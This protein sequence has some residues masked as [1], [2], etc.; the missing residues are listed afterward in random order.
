MI[1]LFSAACICLL[2]V[3]AFSETT[4]GTTESLRGVLIP[5]SSVEY[6]NIAYR[7]TLRE[8]GHGEYLSPYRPQNRYV[9]PD[10]SPVKTLRKVSFQLDEEERAYFFA[11]FDALD[12]AACF[13]TNPADFS[14]SRETEKTPGLMYDS[15]TMDG[16]RRQDGLIVLNRGKVYRFQGNSRNNPVL[17]KEF[18]KIVADMK[19]QCELLNSI[20]DPMQRMKPNS[21]SSENFGDSYFQP[22]AMESVLMG[23]LKT[24]KEGGFLSQYQE[25]MRAIELL[26]SLTTPEEFSAFMADGF[27]KGTVNE[28]SNLLVVL[29]SL[30]NEDGKRLRQ[31]ILEFNNLTPEERARRVVPHPRRNREVLKAAVRAATTSETLQKSLSEMTSN[32]TPYQLAGF[33]SSE[34]SR[35]DEKKAWLL[36]SVILDIKLPPAYRACFPPILFLDLRDRI[37]GDSTRLSKEQQDIVWKIQTDL[38]KEDYPPFLVWLMDHPDSVF[39]KEQFRP[40]IP[41]KMDLLTRLLSPRLE[42]PDPQVRLRTMETLAPLIIQKMPMTSGMLRDYSPSLSFSEKLRQMQ[43]SD[44]DES[45]RKKARELYEMRTQQPSPG[46]IPNALPGNGR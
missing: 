23:F 17:S 21:M 40:Q 45:V 35:M 20:A 8:D 34:F 29:D 2:S 46:T 32:T 7:I 31:M 24:G 43:E 39:Y 9:R 18:W 4:M 26:C 1:V 36:R 41:Q 27:D 22:D 13:S 33:L 12:P 10:T 3:S 30:R 25:F 28:A 15:L 11:C 16:G 38:F 42:S 14:V 6:K 37:P 5:S 19:T 44:P